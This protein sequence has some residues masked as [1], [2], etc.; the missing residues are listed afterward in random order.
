MRTPLLN[1]RRLALDDA[2]TPPDRLAGPARYRFLYAHVL[3]ANQPV[4][5]VLE[6]VFPGAERHREGWVIQLDCPVGTRQ[7]AGPSRSEAL[8]Q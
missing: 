6:R 4:P 1:T 2:A 3:P 8:V 5:V 7:V